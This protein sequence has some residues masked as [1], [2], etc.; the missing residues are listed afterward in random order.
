MPGVTPEAG[1]VRVELPAPGAE[2]VW[3]CLFERDEEVLRAPLAP[4]G[5]GLFAAHV[6]GVGPG[7]RYGFRADGP[8]ALGRFDPSK[9]LL[10]PY[11]RRLEAPLT[12]HPSL[13]IPGEDSAPHLP[14]CVVEAPLPPLDR[15]PIPEQPLIIYELHVRGFTMRHPEIPEALRGTFAGLAHPVAIAHL[16]ALGVTAVELMPSAAWIEERHLPPLGLTNYWGYNPVCPFAPDPRLAPGGMAELRAAVQA[17]RAA[18]IAVIL[19]VVFNHTGEGDAEGPTLNL[20]GLGEHHWYRMGRNESGCG[21][22]LAADRPWG[23]ALVMDALR[24]WAVEAGV[25]GFRLDLATT[26]GRCDPEG[27]FDANAPLLAALRQDPVLRGR[28]IIVEPWDMAGHS[29]GA[30]PRGWGEWNDRFRD[31]VRRFWRGDRGMVGALATRLAGSSDVLPDRAG[32]SVNFVTAHDG[33]TLA[34]LVSFARKH[35]EANGEEN[36]DGSDQNFSWNNGHEGPTEDPA[37]RARRAADARALLATLL[38]ARGIPML[39]M[40]DEIGRTQQ[41]NNNA[42]CQDNAL[43]WMDWARADRAL[44]AFAR[45]LIAARRAHPALHCTWPLSGEVRNGDRDVA[46]LTLEGRPMQDWEAAESLVMLLHCSGDRVLAAFHQGEGAALL[47][48]PPPRWGRRWVLIADSAEPDRMGPV[49]GP[50]GM[51]PRSVLLLAEDGRSAAR[52]GAPDGETLAALAAAAGIET[53]WFDLAGAAHRVPEG[54]VRT[55]L[56]AL[57]LPAE[58]AAQA[59]DSLARRRE[60]PLLPPHVAATAGLALRLPSAAT[61]RLAAALHLE[62]GETRELSLLPQDGALLLPPLPPGHHRLET[63]G[64]LCRITCAPA[65]A[66]RPAALE[67]PR[68]GLTAQTYALRHAADQ[69]MGDFTA[70]AELARA[71]AAEGALWLGLSPPH[72]LHLADRA[73]ASPYQPGDR[74]FLDPILI[75]AAR[76]GPCAA[77]D[78]PLVDYPAAWA[79]KRATL[80]AAWARFDRRDPG[81]QAFRAAGGAALRG[82]ALH[83][84]LVEHLGHGDHRRWPSGLAHVDDHA[85]PGFA[86]RLAEETEFHI[87]LQF[88]AD[89]QLAEAAA[90]GAGLYRDLAVGSAPDGAEAWT[91]ALPFLEGLSI[92]APPDPLGPLGQVWG[93][94]PPDPLAS[95]AE[96]HAGFAALIRANMRHAAALR[97]DHVLGLRRLFLVPDGAPASEGAYLAQDMDGLLAI[98]RLESHR[99]R[100]AVV[101]EDLGTVPEGLRERLAEAGLLS[102]RVLWFEREEGRFTPPAR[103]PRE[104]VACLAT[105]DLPTLAGWWAG[106]DIAERAALGLLAREAAEAARAQ[107]AAERREIVAALREAGQDLPDEAAELPF[108]GPLAAA[109][110]AHLA[111]A[112]SLMLL[113][114]AEDLAGERIAANLPGTDRERPNWRRRLPGDAA[115][116]MGTPLAQAILSAVRRARPTPP[117]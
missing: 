49:E 30:F 2:R 65:R 108:T 5:D 96:G 66:F 53:V 83:C 9:L 110:H 20:R 55:L 50:L 107:R 87:F 52:P 112:P 67:T 21:N 35:N 36:R 14:K 37:I 43:S 17:L 76:L 81:F 73:R 71:A 84:A 57:G 28:R 90:A 38:I 89:R 13:F 103:W 77:P 34:D 72:A 16:R 6:P 58:T 45:R 22:V 44:F 46:W 41:G 56:A 69:G 32:D 114:Q 78:G 116:L 7:A 48:L 79:A 100:C 94:P 8:A 51:A 97:I 42:Y 88:L 40:G 59:R 82:F 63:A 106:E 19:D 99:A 29:L 64:A 70:V 11:A 111:A 92:G 39:S 75:D 10:D 23:L 12:L 74:R 85:V 1:G 54:T 93:V 25:D 68:F 24:H 80:A 91:R 98:I 113:I 86:A 117:P 47:A 60:R 61:R 26:L 4:R 102:Y 105:H 3:F 62:G 15:S 104:A 27:R 101:G 31:D 18:G 115:A 95:A 33:F 109:L